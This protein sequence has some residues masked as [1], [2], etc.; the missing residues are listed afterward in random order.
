MLVNIQVIILL[1]CEQI[2]SFS[3]GLY[4][5][6]NSDSFTMRSCSVVLSANL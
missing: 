4:L 6:I 3:F 5:V 1:L 2:Q